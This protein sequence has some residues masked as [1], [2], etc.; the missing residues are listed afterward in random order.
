MDTNP[1]E[2][3]TIETNNFYY[4]GTYLNSLRVIWWENNILKCYYRG[5]YIVLQ[6]AHDKECELCG[7]IIELVESKFHGNALF[8]CEKCDGLT[9][10]EK[11][12]KDVHIHHLVFNDHL[13]FHN[14][15]ICKADRKKMDAKR[16]ENEENY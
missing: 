14:S 2:K 15:D 4:E 7:M 5:K 12:K 8:A 3:L 9:K 11:E 13:S 16:R 1:E 10:N 6:K